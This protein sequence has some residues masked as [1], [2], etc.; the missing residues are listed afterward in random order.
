MGCSCCLM[1]AIGLTMERLISHPPLMIV[2]DLDHTMVDH[3]DHENLSLLRF[4]SLWEYAYRRDSLLV[5]STARSPIL[6]KE[7][8][9]EKPLLTPDITI[10][11]IG[12][13]IAFGNSMVAD[14]AWVE[15][16][17]TDKW[18]REIVLEETSKFPELTLQPKTE[19]RLHKLDVKIIYSWGKNVDV[20]PRGAGKGEALEY[21]LKKL[22]AEGIFPVN[23]LACGDSEHDAELFSIP[24]VHG[25]MVSNSQE[26]LLKWRSENA[27][28]NLKVIH[29]TERCADGIIQAIGYFNLG[30]NLSPRDVSEFLDRKTDNANPGHEVVRF[31]LFYEKL[32]RG[33]IKNYETYIAS[34]KESCLHAAV[35]FHP[36]GA[37]KSLSDTIDELKK[38]YGDKRGKKFWVWVD[39]ILITDTIPGKWIV[40]FDKW[41][42]CEDERQY[43]K[44]TV[45]FTSKGGDLVW[46]KVKQIW[47]EE[48]EVKDDDNSSWIL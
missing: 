13:E 32:R 36:S 40:K 22:Q 5:F 35:H 45:E 9:K 14:H 26:E 31:Y 17:N 11:S 16:L 28:N 19:Q 23:T 43:C 21:L 38:C 25:V 15:S 2:S 7:L 46:E 44:T 48:P 42:Q 10:T 12:T 30:P 6:Y 33:E 39:Q 41:E 1:L 18:N 24:D 29:S 20:I 3:Q 34:F 4:N 27:L 47:S 8:R 37:E